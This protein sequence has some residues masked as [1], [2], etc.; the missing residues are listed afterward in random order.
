MSTAGS[1]TALPESQTPKVSVIIPAYNTAAFIA[2]TLN[3]VFG[4][5]FRNFEVI[6]INDGA[7]DTTELEVALQ[8]Y[9]SRIRYIQ[10]E[11]RG[12]SGARNA[13]IR[14]A[15][16]EL[17]AFV[18]SDDTWLPE[19]LSAQVQFLDSHPDVCASI[20][21][22]VLFGAGEDIVWRM[23][24][25][26]TGPIL[27]FEDM[28]KRKGGQ[29]PSAM[30]AR[31]QRVLDVGLFDEQTRIGED[32][33]FCARL[34]FPQG[35]IGY[36]GR[37]LVKYR[38]RPGSLTEDPRRRKWL[39]AE[40]QSLRRLGTTL[41]LDEA[42]RKLLEQEI[43][44]AVAALALDDAYHHISVHEFEKAVQCLRS[45]NTHYRDIR[46]G[47]SA[48]CLHVFPRLTGYLLNRRLKRR[49]ARRI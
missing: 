42:Q 28:L 13:G 23:L 40:I 14:L 34:C 7:P 33:E 47:V 25:E 4:Q 12:L 44:A 46:I 27:G 26:G 19:Y 32:V 48:F 31:R 21:D 6:V 11:N 24:K 15:R 10:Q 16:G 30:V 20:S 8:P 17:L 41:D 9:M 1:E 38:Q 37:V 49:P 22:A 43:A 18:D 29:L 2:E 3:S 39:E 5:T 45:A 36:L 35:R